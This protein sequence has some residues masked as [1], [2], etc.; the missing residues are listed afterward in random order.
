M[1]GK[2]YLLDSNIIIDVFR[3]ESK[4]VERIS[5]TQKLFVPVIV[6]GELYYGAYKSNQIARRIAEVKQLEEL[7]TILNVTP[8][9]SQL[10]GEIKQRLYAK[11]KPIPEND[12]WIAAIAIE[13]GLVLITRDKHFEE[14]EG[15]VIERV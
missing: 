1:S 7:V 9:T 4:T 3:G 13:H 12:I 2:R 15:V 11:G 6:I 5:L 8:V 14:V 10:Y